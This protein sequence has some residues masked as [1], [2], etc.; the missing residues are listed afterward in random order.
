[1]LCFPHREER[2]AGLVAQRAPLRSFDPQ[3]FR[4]E[5]GE[6]LAHLRANACGRQ[7]DHLES[8]EGLHVLSLLRC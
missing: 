3:H 6:H 5:I 7:V 2:E 4:A 1:M 8:F